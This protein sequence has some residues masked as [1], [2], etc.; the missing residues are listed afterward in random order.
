LAAGRASEKEV[1]R[2]RSPREKE[3]NRREQHQQ[4]RAHVAHE[5]LV[6]RNHRGIEHPG[7]LSVRGS[8]ILAM[9]LTS[10]ARLEGRPLGAYGVP[11]VRGAARKNGLELA[12]RPTSTSGGN[13][14]PRG[15]TPTIA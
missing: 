7:V 15:I 6:E 4:G 13:E 8:K 5:L 3:G 14:K 10:P 11:V 2:S 12:R 1:H 9:A